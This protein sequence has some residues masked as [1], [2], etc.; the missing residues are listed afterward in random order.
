MSCHSRQD[1]SQGWILFLGRDD[2]VVAVVWTVT[3]AFNFFGSEPSG[4][5]KSAVT[6]CRPGTGKLESDA[7]EWG[8]FA[9]NLPIGDRNRGSGK[10]D[11]TG[12]RITKRLPSFPLPSVFS[13]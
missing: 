5:V 4:G 3:S 13:L 6:S 2:A 11:A 10:V 9:V 7:P 8:A 1:K 12:N